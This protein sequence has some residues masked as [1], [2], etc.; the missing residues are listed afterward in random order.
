MRSC[1]RHFRSASPKCSITSFKLRCTCTFRSSG[2][3]FPSVCV[4]HAT[5]STFTPTTILSPLPS[6]NI[7]S[8]AIGFEILGQRSLPQRPA[9]CRINYIPVGLFAPREPLW[10]ESARRENCLFTRVIYTPVDYL[11]SV[12]SLYIMPTVICEGKLEWMSTRLEAHYWAPAD[13]IP[14]R[15]HIWK[16]L[17]S[18]VKIKSMESFNL[19]QYQC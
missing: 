18:R 16:T 1:S 11:A 19:W 14:E 2:R 9:T 7:C 6:A 3:A 8:A 13:L 10:G 5:H 15:Y 12:C 17:M 4:C